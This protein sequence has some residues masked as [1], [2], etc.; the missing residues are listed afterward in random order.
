MYLLYV[1]SHILS[2]MTLRRGS[3]NETSKT[4]ISF[5]YLARLRVNTATAKT[6]STQNGTHTQSE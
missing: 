4:K 6:T 3:R 2:S 1:Y 5:A